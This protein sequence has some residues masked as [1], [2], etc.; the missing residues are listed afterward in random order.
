MI[1]LAK[2]GSL[3]ASNK[4]FQYHPTVYTH[5]PSEADIQA[6]ATATQDTVVWLAVLAFDER[7]HRRDFL[8]LRWSLVAHDEEQQDGAYDQLQSDDE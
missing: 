2:A 7:L 1:R 8:V 5:V 6:A 4:V 3:F